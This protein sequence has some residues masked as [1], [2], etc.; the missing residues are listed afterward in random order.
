MHMNVIRSAV[1]TQLLRVTPT[2]KV[3]YGC[4]GI[5]R[6]QTKTRNCTHA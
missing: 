4:I 5:T 1:S 2:L 6:I 3:V